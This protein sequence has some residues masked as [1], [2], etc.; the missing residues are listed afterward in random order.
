MKAKQYDLVLLDGGPAG[1]SG[2]STGT[3][4]L[5]GAGINAGTIPSKKLRKTAL[6]LSEPKQNASVWLALK[7]RV[8]FGLWLAS[9]VS[10]VCV[11]AHDTAATWLMNIS[12]S[13]TLLLSLMAT[14][15]SLPFFLSFHP[16]GRGSRGFERQASSF[17]RDLPLV[18]VRRGIAGG[19]LL[20]TLGASIRD[21]GHGFF[22]GDR[23]CV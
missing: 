2:A 18:G 13:S 3:G 5:G 15:A 22:A 9:V 1:A 6:A 7:N 11:A 16:S 23:L 17:H 19:F 12:G 21:P 8:F 4:E 20:V 14:A 10:G